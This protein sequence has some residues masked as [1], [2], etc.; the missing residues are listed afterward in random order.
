MQSY[1]IIAASGNAGKIRE[2]QEIF[3]S[4]GLPIRII[5]MREA[6][7]TEEI[8]ENGNSFSENAEI[9]ARTVCKALNKPALADDS[10]LCVDFLNGAPGIYSARFSGK[11][12]KENRKLLLEK[13]KGASDR[14]AH[15]EC[16]VCLYLPDGKK[17][18]GHGATYGSIL[19]EE[20][21]AHGFGY[22]TLF[23]SDDLQMS[24]GEA[25]DEQK[26]GVSH[27]ARALEDLTG[28]LALKK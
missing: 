24:F 15:F 4:A 10:G 19:K 11:G 17:L 12:E 1:E 25:T 22:D 6:G 26:N 20:R 23:F 2:I 13:L 16:A 27:R 28:K 18:F 14:R 7:Y 5:S 3:S 21:G 9:K 8:E